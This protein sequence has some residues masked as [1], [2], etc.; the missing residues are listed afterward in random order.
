MSLPEARWGGGASLSNSIER[1]GPGADRIAG[2]RLESEDD[3]SALALRGCPRWDGIGSCCGVHR[4]L[5]PRCQERCCLTPVRMLG[6]GHQACDDCLLEGAGAEPVHPGAEFGGGGGGCKNC[7]CQRCTSFSCASSPAIRRWAWIV[8]ETPRSSAWTKAVCSG[9]VDRSAEH[10]E[11]EGRRPIGVGAMAAC[12]E[13]GRRTQNP[14]PHLPARDP[15]LQQVDV[16]GAIP[17]RSPVGPTGPGKSR[18][19]RSRAG[20]PGLR[21]GS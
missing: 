4:V 9:A 17:G 14:R 11:I 18:A 10:V 1:R 20:I 19:P 8:R 13:I 21:A 3:A 16:G 6:R 5:P 2:A 15:Q 12:L 7:W